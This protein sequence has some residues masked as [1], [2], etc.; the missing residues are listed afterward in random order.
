KSG[1][2][3]RLSSFPG[4]NRNPVWSPDERA[5]YYLTEQSGSF[6][7]WRLPLLNGQPGTAL[8]IT[9]FERN[10]VRFLSAANN[11]DLCFGYDGE[12]YTLPAGAPEPQKVK[13]QI[14]LTDSEPAMRVKQYGD[15][16]TEMALSPN[17]KE[18]AIV[19]RGDI[20]VASVDQGQTKRI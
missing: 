10:P 17:S 5:V 13:I 12:I 11:G 3:Q 14:G 8:Q 2:H 15:N 4:E 9:K 20:Y 19:V 18:F 16:V 7:V 6:N 1:D